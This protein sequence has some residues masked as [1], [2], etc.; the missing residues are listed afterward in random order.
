MTQTIALKIVI[1][2]GYIATGNSCYKNNGLW[3]GFN[4]R[5][6]D[7]PPFLLPL[8]G[9]DYE[10]ECYCP[11]PAEPLLRTKLHHHSLIPH[12]MPAHIYLAPNVD[13]V[14]TCS[15]KKFLLIVY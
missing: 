11:H 8:V 1:V 7:Q 9:I 14:A 4:H 3:K 15:R 10:Y 6:L 5:I 2:C 13:L 12:S